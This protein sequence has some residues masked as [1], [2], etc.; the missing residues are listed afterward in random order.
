MCINISDETIALLCSVLAATEWIS[1]QNKRCF[2]LKVYHFLSRDYVVDHVHVYVPSQ[3]H[4]SVESLT[5]SLPPSTNLTRL[6][7][8]IDRVP[9]QLHK[10]Y[11]VK[12]KEVDS[13]DLTHLLV[14]SC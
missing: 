13:T 6:L 12:K 3:I 5:R 8:S 14:V 9:S 11:I 2:L 10:N 4:D 1:Q 7:Y